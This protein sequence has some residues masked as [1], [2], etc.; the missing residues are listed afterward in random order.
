VEPREHNVSAFGGAGLVFFALLYLGVQSPHPLAAT[1]LALVAFSALL[2]TP[3]LIEHVLVALHHP[4]PR[5]VGRVLGWPFKVL[6]VVLWVIFALLL[7]IALGLG[8]VDEPAAG[9]AGAAAALGLLAGCVEFMRR[10][11]RDLAHAV[12]TGGDFD[13]RLEQRFGRSKR[14]LLAGVMFLAGTAL[15]MLSTFVE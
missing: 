4:V 14:W 13:R 5:W 1:G 7:G 2:A 12:S 11:L 8:I 6:R 15:Q 10:Q 3:D 9:T